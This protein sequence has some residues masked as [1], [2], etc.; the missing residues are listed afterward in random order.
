MNI[1]DWYTP[2]VGVSNR[3]VLGLVAQLLVALYV[4][5]LVNTLPAAREET[6]EDGLEGDALDGMERT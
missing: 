4:Q 2:F 5:K 3:Q 6:V 1:K